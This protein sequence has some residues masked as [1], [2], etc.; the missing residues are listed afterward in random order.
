M[1]CYNCAVSPGIYSATQAPLSSSANIALFSFLLF[2]VQV[3]APFDAFSLDPSKEIS[4]YT[5]RVWLKKDGLPQNSVLALAQTPDGYLWIG[6]FEGLARFD[7][8]NFRIY[9]PLNTPGLRGR[10]VR[11]LSVGRDSTLWIGLAEGGGL[12]R[13]KNENLTPVNLGLKDTAITVTSVFEGSDDRLWVGSDRGLLCLHDGSVER[14]YNSSDGLSRE[15]V[16]GIA[17][18]HDGRILVAAGSPFVFEKN[19]FVNLFPPSLVEGRVRSIVTGADGCIWMGTMD[20]GVT[21]VCNGKVTH[22]SKAQGLPSPQ[23]D[24]LLED[25]AGVMWVGTLGGLARIHGAKIA[26]YGAGDGLSGDE[27]MSLLSD[28]EGNL[29]AGVATGGLNRFVEGTF[30]TYFATG[31]P[32]RNFIYSVFEDRTGKIL[33]GAAS[34]EVL[35][36]TGGKFVPDPEIPGDLLGIPLSFLRQKNGQLWVGTARGLYIGKNGKFKHYPLGFIAA[37]LEDPHGRVWVGSSKG[38]LY[39]ARDGTFPV[40]PVATPGKYISVRLLHLDN[41]GR[42][43]VGTAMDGLF[44]M[45]IPPAGADLEREHPEDC[46]WFTPSD[47]L[48]SGWISSLVEEKDGTVWVTAYGGGL[49]RIKDDAVANAAGGDLTEVNLHTLREDLRGWFW[50]SS[51]NGVFR[52]LKSDVEAYLDGRTK[53]FSCSQFGLS[54]GMASDECNGGSINSSAQTPDGRMWIPTS[55]GVSVVNPDSLPIN[56]VA[57]ATNL[58]YVRVGRRDFPSFRDISSFDEG[59]VEFGYNAVSLSAPERVQFRV[60]LEGFDG[61]WIDATGRR[62]ASYTNLPPG[63]YIFLVQAA[64]ADGAW[65]TAGISYT[66]TIKPRFYQTW[67]FFALC[68]SLVM[69][70]GAGLHAVVRRDRDRQLVAAQLESKLAQAQLKVLEMQ[71]QPHFLFNTLNGISVLIREDPDAATRMIARLSEFVRIAL[72][73]SGV[74]EI[75][76]REELFFV[77]RYLQIELLRFADRLSVQQDIKE[78]LL[79]ALVP[80][81]ILQPIIENAIRHGIS[82][83][84]GPVTIQI[85]ACRENGGLTLHVRDNGAGLAAGLATIKEG[86]G[87]TNTRARLQ[88]LYGEHQKLD[89]SSPSSGG[90]DVELRIPYHTESA[91]A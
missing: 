71:M 43:W 16:T 10:T 72:D 83:R 54:A 18:D 65:N 48:R 40:F 15:V 28:R 38:L 57:P 39:R 2:L 11:C 33:A 49:A 32:T 53:S 37:I 62:I 35:A 5:H 59:E 26:T 89:L 85:A 4:Q 60:K 74:Q 1:S 91:R 84:R 73:R 45:R 58:E 88:Q 82:K 23:V 31:N 86:I 9:T 75:P 41:Q 20:N 13:L 44:R 42:I 25:N 19:R 46:R 12:A 76:L 81:M 7:G 22:Y 67:W 29:W 47:G 90:V 3:L 34:R 51:N 61:S 27:V 80:T 87:L 78:D 52:V 30:T 17:E 64:N 66:F 8:I 6:T 36:F 70:V 21:S 24:A 50:M 79:D 55:M 14:R 63:R 69:M 68:G 77:D 56:M